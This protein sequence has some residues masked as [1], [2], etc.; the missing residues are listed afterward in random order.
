MAVWRSDPELSA[1]FHPQYPDH[2]QVVL[3]DGEPRRTQ[4]KP[5]T[6]W[7]EVTALHA[8]VRFASVARAP[9]APLATERVHWIE[10]PVYRGTLLHATHALTIQNGQS[11]LF[12]VVPGIPYPLQV[13][14]A[15]LAER[16]QWAFRPCDRCGADQGLD[17][18]TTMARTRFGDH[19]GSVPIRFT[20][21]CP[22]G[23]TMELQRLD[24]AA[25]PAHASEPPPAPPTRAAQP[26]PPPPPPRAMNP[27][28]HHRR[29]V[30]SSLH[31]RRRAPRGRALSRRSRRRAGSGSPIPRAEPWHSPMSTAWPVRRPRAPRS[32]IPRTR[33]RSG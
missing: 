9:G 30:P 16:V 11:L 4:R 22:C 15:Y 12:V 29:H 8:R 28:H 10:R 24:A 1:R 7:I 5:E 26:T 32:V 23:G 31:H 27:H 21:F 25:E 3:H 33:P 13:D 6:C 20:A 17:L 14:E 18:P 2:V 19:P